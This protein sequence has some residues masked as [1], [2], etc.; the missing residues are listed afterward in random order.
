MLASVSVT[1]A[2]RADV[3]TQQV[4][5][6]WGVGEWRHVP[7]AGHLGAVTQRC[8]CGDQFAHHSLRLLRGLT[9]HH[10]GGADQLPD[11]TQAFK[12]SPRVNYGEVPRLI[13]KDRGPSCHR[14]GRTLPACADAPASMLEEC[15]KK[16]FGGINQFKPP[17]TDIRPTLGA[18]P[19]HRL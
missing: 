5:H 19:N 3:L 17:L 16:S 6:F 12:A 13:P 1:G 4:G 8:I 10:Q 11:V 18:T 14:S 2:G 7:G 15:R 9:M